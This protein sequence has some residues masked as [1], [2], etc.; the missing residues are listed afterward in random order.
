MAVHQTR[1]YFLERHGHIVDNPKVGPELA[2]GYWAPGN[3]VT[4]MDL[5]ERM[6][7]K[8]FSADAIVADANMTTDQ[9]IAEAHRLRDNLKNIPEYAGALD[10]DASVKIIHGRETITQFNNGSEFERANA[11]FRSWVETHYPKSV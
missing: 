9:A 5:V 2:A 1:E 7:G 4:F 11:E 8:P 6:T 10:L 3:S